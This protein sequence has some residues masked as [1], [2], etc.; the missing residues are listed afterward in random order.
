[1]VKNIVML[2]MILL[3]NDFIAKLMLI[4]V[5]TTSIGFPIL[6][7][8]LSIPVTELH[9]APAYKLSLLKT[10]KYR[11]QLNLLLTS[12]GYTSTQGSIFTSVFRSMLQ[13]FIGQC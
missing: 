11:E 9:H 6:Q 3:I 5:W 4:D 12:E 13:F 2:K 8:V 7:T 1:M 10:T